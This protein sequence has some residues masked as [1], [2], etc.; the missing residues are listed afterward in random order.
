M[1]TPNI[2]TS[3]ETIHFKWEVSH[4]SVI[5][6]SII[7][8]KISSC[9]HIRNTDERTDVAKTLVLESDEE[10]VSFDVVMLFKTETWRLKYAKRDWPKT[11]LS[12]REVPRT[13][14][15]CWNSVLLQPSSISEVA[16]TN[17]YMEQLYQLC[18]RIPVSVVVANLV[19]EHI[20]QKALAPFHT[21]PKVYFRFVDDTICVL[22]RMLI[23]E[24][25]QHLNNQHPK[26]QFTVERYTS[27]GL[28]F[29]DSLNRVRADGT[30]E[31]SVP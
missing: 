22:K 4:R 29:L 19:M 1:R 10:L 8:A 16:I 6:S 25:H 15:K 18:I 26:I 21:K 24:F 2:S 11:L 5:F 31:I 7:V 23:Q 9:F 30:I 17:K 12:I 28:P 3:Q 20:E 13:S 27:K 14:A